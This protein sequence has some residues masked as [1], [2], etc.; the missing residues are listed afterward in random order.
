MKTGEEK[1]SSLS[2]KAD[3]RTKIPCPYCGQLQLAF[4]R[5]IC[6]N[7]ASECRVCRIF[8]K[9]D[10][11]E[12]TAAKKKYQRRAFMVVAYKGRAGGI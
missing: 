3:G 9:A 1:S 10:R 7:H 12:D 8:S 4:A 6:R 2:K 5:H 11:I